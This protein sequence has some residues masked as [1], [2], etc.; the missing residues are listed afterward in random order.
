M[1]AWRFFGYSHGHE[2]FVALGEWI[3]P[4]L[5]LS[6]RTTTLGACVTA[7][8]MANVV[9]VNFT[10]ELPV[11][12]FSSCLLA[13][14]AYL[15]LVDSKRLL[16]VFVLNEPVSPRVLPGA[17]IRRRW[18]LVSA[19]VGWVVLALG[20]SF[21]YIALG[22]SRSTPLAGAWTVESTGTTPAVT[23]RTVYFERGLQDMYPGSL[24]RA[25]D[26]QPVRFRYQFD[27]A[28]R[29]LRMTFSDPRSADKR[30]DGTYEVQDGGR[31]RLRG[32]LDE[33]TVDIH[34][35]RKR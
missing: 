24:R 31:L 34:L 28:D 9:V 4:A 6:W 5:L 8:V 20:Y 15:I 2:L 13:L 16:G 33:Q 32:A 26:D 3:G 21:M 35:V 17:C 19:K 10:H 23:W 7:A 25:A 11:Q 27:A 22:D 29:H 12:R 1:L 18:L 14:T 30:F